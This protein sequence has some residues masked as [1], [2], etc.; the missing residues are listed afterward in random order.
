MLMNP[1]NGD[2]C[3]EKPQKGDPAD[4]EHLL[5]FEPQE[6]NAVATGDARAF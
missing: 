4:T 1:Q 2:R 3:T 6:V 5:A